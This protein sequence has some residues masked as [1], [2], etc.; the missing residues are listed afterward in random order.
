M[1]TAPIVMIGRSSYRLNEA[2][3]MEMATPDHLQR[4][5][6]VL[7][8]E[9]T[10]DA[11]RA[12]AALMVLNGS[13]VTIDGTSLSAAFYLCTGQPSPLR[14]HARR[15]GAF[16]RE[17]RADI[18]PEP[19]VRQAAA[20]RTAG[21]LASMNPRDVAKA[22]GL[23]IWN[24]RRLASAF[25][26]HEKAEELQLSHNQSVS[27]YACAKSRAEVVRM[28]AAAGQDER[29][30][31]SHITRMWHEGAWGSHMEGVEPEPGLWLQIGTEKP[32]RVW[33]KE[34]AE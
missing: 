16:Q 1:S 24:G 12:A 28:V 2:G 34:K 14:S 30:L 21:M 22:K 13:A 27:L 29:G 10:D 32:V 3:R 23:K 11:V 33:P 5:Y 31:E 4:R 8:T 17:V 6:W 15:V 26:G 18:A 20:E 7:V 9:H 25:L 19:T